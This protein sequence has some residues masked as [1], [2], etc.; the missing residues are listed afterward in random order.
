MKKIRTIF[1]LLIASAIVLSFTSCDILSQMGAGLKEDFEKWWGNSNEEQAERNCGIAHAMT[2]SGDIAYLDENKVEQTLH[3]DTIDLNPNFGLRGQLTAYNGTDAYEYQAEFFYKENPDNYAEGEFYINITR[4][5]DTKDNK[6]TTPNHAFNKFDSSKHY[7]RAKNVDLTTKTTASI[8]ASEFITYEVYEEAHDKMVV[9][10]IQKHSGTTDT[11]GI[12]KDNIFDPDERDARFVYIETF[13]DALNNYPETSVVY[14]KVN[15]VY[16]YI[17]N[18]GGD[19]LELMIFSDGEL[20]FYPYE[21][22]RREYMMGMYS[23]NQGS[24]YDS[25]NR[26]DYT[27]NKAAR[28][29]IRENYSNINALYN[30]LSAKAKKAKEDAKAKAKEEYEDS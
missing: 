18:I 14:E 3:C 4:V 13:N 9:Y 23:Y 6:W 22:T 1:T 11:T 29:W 10:I 27:K 24:Y 25:N 7:Y 19:I 5:W 17:A 21:D 8:N 28:K 20:F 15:G 12:T 2:I 26:L 16:T 30:D